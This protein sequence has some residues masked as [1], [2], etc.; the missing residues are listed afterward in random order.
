MLSS[1]TKNEASW[2]RRSLDAW[3]DRRLRSLPDRAFCRRVSL[4]GWEN[5][6]HAIETR[7]GLL[8]TLLRGGLPGTAER[9]L[10]LFAS[11]IPLA[12]L[13]TPRAAEALA[14]G[15]ILYAPEGSPRLAELAD[16]PWERLFAQAHL[17]A[18]TGAADVCVVLSP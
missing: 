2:L 5:V 16:Q 14:V 11:A 8:I 6:A 12:T 17:E 13:A 3:R 4:A 15:G 7:R 18:G 10:V 9:A 1:R